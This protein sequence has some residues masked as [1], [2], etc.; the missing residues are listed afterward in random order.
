MKPP[1][2]RREKTVQLACKHVFHDLCI[3]GWAIVGKKARTVSALRTLDQTGTLLVHMHASSVLNLA[4]A[5][6][7]DMVQALFV[8]WDGCWLPTWGS[9]LLCAVSP[10]AQSAFPP[11]GDQGALLLQAL[12]MCSHVTAGTEAA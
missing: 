10:R 3:R 6:E 8:L 1:G 5:P 12:C 11:V 2:W 4:C 7:D 9:I